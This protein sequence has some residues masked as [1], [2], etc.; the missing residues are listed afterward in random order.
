MNSL[1]RRN[2]ILGFVRALCIATALLSCG[3]ASAAETI[4]CSHNLNKNE[5]KLIGPPTID[6]SNGNVGLYTS[7]E[8]G[9]YPRFS[10]L[11]CK[12]ANF[13][14]II[15]GSDIAILKR[16]IDRAAAA[17]ATTTVE[18]FSNSLSSVTGTTVIN[19][20]SKRNELSRHG[21]AC[22]EFYRQDWYSGFPKDYV[23][24]HMSP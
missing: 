9:S 21:C 15:Y 3:I 13:A 10:L 17:G 12:T 1:I 22:I 14:Q 6:M 24:D 16:L 11:N 8:F 23:F 5:L 19:A 4:V 20:R 7:A 2:Q 18:I